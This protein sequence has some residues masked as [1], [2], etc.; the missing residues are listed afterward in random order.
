MEVNQR[1]GGQIMP[2]NYYVFV[3]WQSGVS[4]ICKKEKL[5]EDRNYDLNA[6][7]FV[8]WFKDKGVYPILIIMMN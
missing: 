4:F 1:Y 8:I 6:S 7:K 5:S 3:L 2:D